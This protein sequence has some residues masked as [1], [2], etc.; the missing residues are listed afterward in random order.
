MHSATVTETRRVVYDDS[1][2]RGFVWASIAFGVI[3]LLVGLVIALQLS[4]PALNLGLS[5]TSFGR[6]RP[7]HTNAVIFAVG[8]WALFATSYHVVQRTNQTPLFLPGLAKFTFS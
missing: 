2:V 8:G 1:T 3:G 7:L 6:L 5:F 4:F